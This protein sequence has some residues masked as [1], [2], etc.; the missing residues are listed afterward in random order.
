MS[1][2]DYNPLEDLRILVVDDQRSMRS[3]L[4]RLLNEI[5]I[6]DII[7]GSS[8]E[9]ALEKIQIPYEKAPDL[10][11]CDLY[12]EHMDGLEFSNLVRRQKVEKLA[13]IPILILTGEQDKMI[14]GVA[15]QAG[16]TKVLSKPI[17]APELKIEISAAIGFG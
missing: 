8:G 6:R 3:I 16:A 15:K 7:E 9:D 10:V 17:S 14:V 11:I 13:G 4:R 5:G 1:S 2:M 12:M